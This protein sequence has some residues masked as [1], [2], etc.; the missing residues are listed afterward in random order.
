MRAARE[1]RA[2]VVE[3]AGAPFTLIPAT[4]DSC[5]DT[6]IIV[7]I[8]AVGIC[9]TDLAV[10]DGGTPIPPFPA[11]LGHEGSGIVE[12]VGSKVTRLQPGDHVVLSF[13][14]CGHCQACSDNKPSRC[15]HFIAKNL[16][17]CRE[18][19]SHT[20]HRADGPVS[21]SFFGQSSFASHVVVEERQA[22]RVDRDLPLELLAPLGCGLQTGAGTVLNRL[23][24]A[25]GSSIVI[26][27]LG[28][29]G[30][31][32]VMAAKIA[33]CNPIVAVDLNQDR[34]NLAADFGATHLVNGARPDA[35]EHI[36]EITGGG[37]QSVIEATGAATAIVNA[38]SSARRGGAV[39]LLG[40]AAPG[41]VISL[42]VE[43][44]MVGTIQT[45]TE[46]DSVPDT[47]IPKL[48]DY[49]RQGVFPFDRLV[50][51]YDFADINLACDDSCAGRVV[52]PVLRLD[53]EES[54][55]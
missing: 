45:V 9:H 49:Y 33:G 50:R 18:D 8:V 39:C 38:V 27:G 34:F 48:I 22:V 25:P 46:G 29:V 53:R 13:A 43:A 5:R 4:L 52:K 14:S 26:F 44:L 6:E 37:S 1:I 30:L 10:R 31:A 20:L 36:R 23:C 12:E 51:Y 3:K 7:R 21:G 41:T 32:A 17:G 2:A 54:P 40:M 28:T 16:S 55:A 19:G 42:P 15:A 47:F 35:V 11:V 24:P